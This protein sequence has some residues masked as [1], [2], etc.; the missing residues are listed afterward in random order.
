MSSPSTIPRPE[1][2]H[3]ELD[4]GLRIPS[5]VPEFLEAT[6]PSPRRRLLAG[7]VIAVLAVTAIVAVVWQ[8]EPEGVA[9]HDGWMV[10]VPTTTIAETDEVRVHDGWSVNIPDPDARV[11]DGWSVNVPGGG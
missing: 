10:S 7:L 3:P 1:L 9:V 5:T 11:H 8:G 2:E 6:R 4:P